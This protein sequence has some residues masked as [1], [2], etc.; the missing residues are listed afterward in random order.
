MGLYKVFVELEIDADSA[1]EAKRAVDDNFGSG[2][3]QDD[4]VEYQGARVSKLSTSLER[5]V[6]V[7][8]VRF[9]RTDD[10]AS[11][12]LTLVRVD[13]E[14][15]YEPGKSP[16]RVQITTGPDDG[17]DFVGLYSLDGDQLNYANV[18]WTV[19][20]A[21]ELTDDEVESIRQDWETGTSSVER[22]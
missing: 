2:I 8:A 22:I 10:D 1:E 17:D 21:D 6:H 16:V 20:S 9:R 4:L 14:P 18:A 19:I 11:E 7:S 15:G 12:V 13:Q 5:S 3:F